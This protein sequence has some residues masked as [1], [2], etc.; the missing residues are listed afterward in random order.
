MASSDADGPTA[1]EKYEN[2]NKFRQR[3][4]DIKALEAEARINESR[5]SGLL[6]PLVIAIF[7]AAL[8]VGGNAYVAYLNGEIEARKSQAAATLESRRTGATLMMDAIRVCEPSQ[9]RNNLRVLLD[10]Q[11]IPDGDLLRSALGTDQSTFLLPPST[12]CV[13]RTA[14]AATPTSPQ[15]ST[16]ESAYLQSIH[17]PYS[18]PW[19]GDLS[20]EAG[21][22]NV[23]V[24]SNR[25]E[26]TLE[27]VSAVGRDRGVPGCTIRFGSGVNVLDRSNRDP[28][29]SSGGTY[30]LN[31]RE[32]I[33]ISLSKREVEIGGWIGVNSVQGNT[34]NIMTSVNTPI[35]G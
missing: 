10:A 20:I 21:T 17:D 2:D 3:E 25:R 24:G 30:R 31:I 29:D 26:S 8:A 32:R 6:G 7:T 23:F 35:G 18:V 33:A 12:P 34:C 19:G 11:L 15:T 13:P 14:S 28:G 9:A 16:A 4:L 1:A 27:V 22:T 5:K